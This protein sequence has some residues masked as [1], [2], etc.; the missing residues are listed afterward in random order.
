M[1]M[2]NLW[3][4][5]DAFVFLCSSDKQESLFYVFRS[6]SFSLVF[7]LHSFSKHS[8]GCQS[9]VSN[10]F[11]WRSPPPPFFFGKFYLNVLCS[12][13]TNTKKRKFFGCFE[14]ERPFREEL[15]YVFRARKRPLCQTPLP[16][17]SKGNLKIYS[18]LKQLHVDLCWLKYHS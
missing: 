12:L 7:L 3:A 16:F 13:L 1:L 6:C 4:L 17:F 14:Q 8:T 11:N 9:G 5:G 15:A 10:F 18:V 2:F